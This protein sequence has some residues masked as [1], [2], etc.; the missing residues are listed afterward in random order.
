MIGKPALLEA[1]LT[2]R[3]QAGFLGQFLVTAPVAIFA[4]VFRYDDAADILN[5]IARG[6]ALAGMALCAWR[7]AA[8]LLAPL[9]RT[10]IQMHRN[11]GVC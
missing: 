11:S 7:S 8:I 3:S 6:F 4:L 9:P 10:F 2:I 1:I 5:F